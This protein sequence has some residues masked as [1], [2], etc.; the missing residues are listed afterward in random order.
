MG[1]IEEINAEFNH[2]TPANKAL[3][4]YVLTHPERFLAQTASQIAQA[5]GVSAAS[6]VRFVKTLNYPGLQAFKVALA[7]SQPQ[8]PSAKPQL[9]TLV[10]PDDALATIMSKLTQTYHNT[11]E[12][13][14]TQ[15]DA[16]AITDSI[17]AL[18][19]ARRVFVLGVGAS[20]LAAQDLYLKLLRAGRSVVYDEDPHAAIEHVYFANRVSDLVIVYSYSGMTAEPLIAARQAKANGTTLIAVTRNLSSPLAKLAD[21]TLGLPTTEELVRIGAIS[22]LYAQL[23]VGNL[24]FLG[25]FKAQIPHMEQNYRET[26]ALLGQLKNT[27]DNDH[28]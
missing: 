5:A 6:T 19:H 10:Q 17:A 26:S 16:N 3:A 8:A 24:L 25:A 4:R 1:L 21:H 15:L 9:N 2:L 23:Y 18:R 27:E 11:T 7:R 20:A 14:T 22:S 28:D 12:A 13:L